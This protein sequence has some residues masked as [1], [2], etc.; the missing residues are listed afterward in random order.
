MYFFII[1]IF[2]EIK[3]LFMY[4]LAETKSAQ[5]KLL[6]QNQKVFLS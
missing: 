1:S 2:E 5:L 3:H 6:D 4:F